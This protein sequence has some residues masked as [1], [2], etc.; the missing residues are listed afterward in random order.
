MVSRYY[1]E[2]P[3]SINFNLWFI[4]DGLAQSGEAR[5]YVEDIDWVFHQ[6]DATLDA[7]ARGRA[8]WRVTS[9]RCEVPRH[10]PGSQPGARVAL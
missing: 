9:G 8:R 4:K 10:R 5:H 1:P 3:M 6:K 2:E 7:E